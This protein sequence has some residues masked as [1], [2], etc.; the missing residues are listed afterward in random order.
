MLQLAGLEK[1]VECPDCGGTD[2]KKLISAPFLPSSV[3]R[4]ANDEVGGCCADAPPKEN[5]CENG[6][7]A[8]SQGLH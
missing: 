7:S 2:L 3:G 5:G 6:C 4:P 1:K 8:C